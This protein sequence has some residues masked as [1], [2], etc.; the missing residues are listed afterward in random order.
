MT[1]PDYHRTPPK[2]APRSEKP[3]KKKGTS[4]KPAKQKMKE[5]GNGAGRHR[6]NPPMWYYEK[7]RVHQLDSTI[8]YASRLRPL[9]QNWSD[10]KAQK[11]DNIINKNYI[12]VGEDKAVIGCV[13][14]YLKEGASIVREASAQQFDRMCT[15]EKK[16]TSALGIFVNSAFT[17]DLITEFNVVDAVI[18]I[19]RH[20]HPKNTRDRQLVYIERVVGIAMLE[21]N[22]FP[23]Y[24]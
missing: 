5:N 21:R 18:E 19:M 3:T 20:D 23:T 4:N 2:V 11:V 22:G 6:E 7:W 8:S 14:A 1:T 15:L 9:I 24:E 17:D 10:E 12:G 16:W 13:L